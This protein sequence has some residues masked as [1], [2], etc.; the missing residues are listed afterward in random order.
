MI[1][2]SVGFELG[3]SEKKV[4]TLTTRFTPRPKPTWLSVQCLFSNDFVK[5]LEFR[6]LQSG[7]IA[8]ISFIQPLYRL[9]AV[10]PDWAIYW[11][12]GKFLKALATINLPK[13]LTFL[14]NF[15]NGVKI[16]HFSREIIFGQL[17][18]TFFLVTL[19]NYQWSG[20]RYIFS[21]TS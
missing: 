9:S 11:T 16:Y 1:L 5:L 6:I 15:Y 8:N 3:S 10:W 14:G 20:Q 13:S 17:L 4:S 21:A 7:A 19:I 18:Y 2:T 12:L